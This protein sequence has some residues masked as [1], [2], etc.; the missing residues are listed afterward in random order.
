MTVLNRYLLRRNLFLLFAILALGAGVYVLSDLFQRIDVFLDS[1]LG[2]GIIGLYYLIKLP[3]IVSQILPAVFLLAMVLQL[4]LMTKSRETV[5]LQSGGVSPS[6]MLRFIIV[7]GLIWSCLQFAFSQVL[8]VYGERVSDRLW[9]EDVRGRDVTNTFIENLLF[10]QGNYV[11]QA[12][13]AW[14]QRERAE[15]VHIYKLTPDGKGIEASYSVKSAES[16]PDGWVLH[17]VE[18]IEPGAYAYSVHERMDIDLKQDLATFR[19]YEEKVSFSELALPQL[20]ETIN[21]LEM[22]GTNVE[23]MRTELYGRFAHAGSILVMGLL[24]LALTMRADSLY[25]GVVLALVSTF[26]FYV[27]GSFFS[28]M[29]QG[30][31]LPP[32]LAAWAANLLFA[33]LAALFI[34]SNYL[35]TVTRKI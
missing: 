23:S 18:F 5:A 29:G 21:R 26:F 16:G 35:R 9:Q 3:L 31:S 13:R 4:M 32:P 24:A 14:P 1:G 17:N 20:V 19:T 22:A 25:L 12:G 15:N 10:T 6:A 34:F 33:G 27:S 2:A 11:V 8:G 28:A 7:Y 30:G